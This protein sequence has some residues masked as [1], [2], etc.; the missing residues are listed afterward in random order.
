M[1]IMIKLVFLL[2]V[3]LWLYPEFSKSQDLVDQVNESFTDINSVTVKGIFCDVDVE[4]GSNSTVTLEGEIR[5]TKKYE[6]LRIKFTKTGNS[7]EVWVEQPKNITG[8]VKGFLNL[9]IPVTTLLK[10]ENISGSIKVS[11][12]GRDEL[13]LN[14]I[15][16]SIIAG[17][18]P[19]TARLKTVSGSIKASVIEGD[20]S[21]KAVSGSINVND[22]KGS[23]D[24]SSVSGS[25][26]ASSIIKEVNASSVSG[27]VNLT[28]I[29]SAV[30]GK[31]VSGGLHFT[32]VKGNI[33]AN[34][35]SGGISLT[36]IV[37]EINASATSGSIKGSSV[38]LTGNSS[39]NNTSGSVDIIL[40]NNSD[41][42]AFD[43]HS[44]SGSL[45]AAGVRSSKK[46]VTGS[47][48]VK[49]TGFTA[50]GSQRYH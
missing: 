11:G 27:S 47:G 10:V 20:V 29:F 40:D 49:I 3:I 50:S 4:P 37:G 45:E 42:L 44:G 1:M 30:K 46:L 33:T 23:A 26:N 18:I 6:D 48:P 9:S 21:A 12:V 17:N 39:F 32:N 31:T 8:Q 14:A 25:I 24:L 7:L 16:G 36:G 34:S 22:I 41:A 43:L 19:C 2:S 15:S 35:T 13:L 38:M 5:A 28:D